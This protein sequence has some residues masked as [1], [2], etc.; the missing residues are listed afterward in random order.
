MKLL[1][2]SDIHFRYDIPV[3]RIDNFL[4]LQIDTLEFISKVALKNNCPIIIAGDLFYRPKPTNSIFLENMYFNIFKDNTIYF[5]HGNNNHDLLYGDYERFEENSIAVLSKFPNWNYK[6][7]SGY[8]DIENNI[9]LNM[10]NFNEEIK[11]IEDEDKFNICIM[12]KYCDKEN[13]PFFI[14]NG[15]TAKELLENYNYDVYIV[16]DQHKAF[17]YKQKNR[18]VFNTGSCTRQS[19]DEKEYMPSIILFDTKEMDY[20]IIY[21]PDCKQSLKSNV[22]KEENT[23]KQLERENRLTSFIELVNSNK[24]VSFSF[25]DNLAKY[26]KENT[27]QQEII[28][29]IEEILE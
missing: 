4:Q 29:I 5:I 9:R 15:V 19:I 23:V 6:K 17:E 13:L 10:F 8:F 2:C 7:Y 28:N 16:G 1:F 21:L 24:G 12:H 3:N 27:I 20:E 18:F 11:D 26:C 22:F 25:K 14:K